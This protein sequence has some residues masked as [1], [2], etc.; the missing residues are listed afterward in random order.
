MSGWKGLLCPHVPETVAFEI[1]EV[2]VESGRKENELNELTPSNLLSFS[3]NA[4]FSQIWILPGVTSSLAGHNFMVDGGGY[5]EN[6]LLLDGVPV[7]HPGHFNSLLP[8]FN[9]DAVKNMVFIRAFSR[10]DWKG[11]FR[12]SQK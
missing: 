2:T 4:L 9:G 10:P 6:Q 3:G 1:E 5:D 12:L 8:V 11:A 7:F